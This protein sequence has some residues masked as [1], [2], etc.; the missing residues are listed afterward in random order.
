MNKLF[1]IYFNLIIILIFCSCSRKAEQQKSNVP[2]DSIDI[3][4]YDETN[5]N[6]LNNVIF[7]KKKYINLEV[8]NGE[9]VI[10]RIDKII[11]KNN[12]YY[13]LDVRKIFLAVFDE[14]GKYLGKIGESKKDYF[15]IADFDVDENGYIYLIDGKLDNFLI[16][17]NNFFLKKSF[18]SPFEIDIVKYLKSKEFLLGLSSWNDKNN[19]NDKV[20]KTDLNLN[21]LET[22]LKYDYSLDDNFWISRY[23]FIETNNAIYYNRP[24][25]NEVFKYDLNGNV[26]KKYYFDFGK[27]NV[28][29]S[30]KSDIDSKIDRYNNYRLLSNFTFV[31]DSLAFGKFWDKRKFKFFY[32]D[33]TKKKLYLENLSEQTELS[34]ICNYDGNELITY[35][36][37]AQFDED[38]LIKL[39]KETSQH[40]R[41]GGFVICKI[42]IN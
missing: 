16:Y 2:I 10:D 31:D 17:D 13:V 36:Y 34:N 29:N 28:P 5:L 21:V 42:T 35:I 3:F 15:N 4:N 26:I 40:L 24:L 9:N 38:N 11:F 7:N 32:I 1:P 25:D 12:K 18:E 6:E 8:I 19:V 23:T 37:A 27:M 33:K 41:D 14:N 20:V 39:P 30:D 22:S